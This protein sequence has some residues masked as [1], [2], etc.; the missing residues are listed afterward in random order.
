MEVMIGWRK[1]GAWGIIVALCSVVTLK[2]VWDKQVTDIPAGVQNVLIWITTAFFMANVVGEHIGSSPAL[3][4]K[5]KFQELT[6]PKP[7]A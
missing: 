2:L 1:L 4:L 3:D 7:G 5:A 6:Q